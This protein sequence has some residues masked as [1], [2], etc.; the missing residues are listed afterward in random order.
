MEQWEAEGFGVGPDPFMCNV[1]YRTIQYLMMRVY[2][3]SIRNGSPNEPRYKH[4]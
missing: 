2:K 1:F 4:F 3:L